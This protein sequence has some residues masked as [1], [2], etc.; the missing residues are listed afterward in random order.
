[1]LESNP[2][3]WLPLLQVPDFLPAFFMPF[4]LQ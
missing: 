2:S 3:V 1:M 4:Y